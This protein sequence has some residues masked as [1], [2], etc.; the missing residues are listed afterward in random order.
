M[1]LAEDPALLQFAEVH[2]HAALLDGE[3][4]VTA[5]EQDAAATALGSMRDLLAKGGF[6]LVR[7]Q[8][9]LGLADLERRRGHPDAARALADAVEHETHTAGY[10][11]LSRQAA[12][13]P[14]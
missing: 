11:R 5:A 13:L 8:V 9:E 4:A 6:A 12:A 14:R 1:R 3:L 7:W 10:L 2:A